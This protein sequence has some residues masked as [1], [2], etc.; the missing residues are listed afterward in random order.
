M[1]HPRFFSEDKQQVEMSGWTNLTV[2][3]TDGGT[4]HPKQSLRQHWQ[5]CGRT[6]N[7]SQMPQKPSV[8][9]WGCIAGGNLI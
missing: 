5:G 4:L 3:Q 6:E 8:A 2:S 9:G 1:G 7:M